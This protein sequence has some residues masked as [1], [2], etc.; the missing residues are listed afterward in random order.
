MTT[1]KLGSR[2]SDVRTLQRY[3]N[4][5]VDGIFGPI[6]E[7]TV[8]LYQKSKGLI[9]D[10][11]V[12]PKTWA[13]LGVATT[14]KRMITEIIIHCTATPEGT[15]FTVAQIKRCHLDRGFNDIGYHYV[16]YRDGTIHK[17]RAEEKVGA[18]ATGHNAISIGICYV[19]GLAKDGKTGKDTR[20]P[21]QKAAL[22]NLIK[23]LKQ[24]YPTIKLVMGHRDTSPDLNHNGVIE[25]S[26][27]IKKCPCFDAI[28]EY[29]DI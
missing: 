5:A 2:G 6:T 26:E 9:P 22:I 24:R 27:Y 3:L 18:H 7:E 16:I 4:L 29:K 19:G 25:P 13:A 15:D 10:G 1:L 14:M 17:G 8:K 20:T 12:G 23:E 21:A 11:V 28:P